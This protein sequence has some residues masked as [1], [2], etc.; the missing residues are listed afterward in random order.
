MT[1]HTWSKGSGLFRLLGADFM[2]DEIL[3]VWFIEMNPQPLLFRTRQDVW[4]T[5]KYMIKDIIEIQYGLLRSRMTRVRR[6]MK[7]YISS[8]ML[9]NNTDCDKESWRKMF[10]SVNKDKMDPQFA[11]SPK[12]GWKLVADLSLEGKEAFKGYL[13]DA[14]FE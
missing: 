9:D 8:C 11:P 1:M 12:N 4:E 5:T 3:N 6:F 2:I 10:Y 14:C 13:H 7:D